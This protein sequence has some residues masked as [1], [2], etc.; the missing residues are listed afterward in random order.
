MK[1]WT[2]LSH[3]V[4]MCAMSSPMFV[5]KCARVPVYSGKWYPKESRKCFLLEIVHQNTKQSKWCM[6]RS[7]VH[8]WCLIPFLISTLLSLY[9]TRG[10]FHFFSHFLPPYIHQL[11]QV[12]TTV[13]EFAHVYPGQRLSWAFLSGSASV[14]R[15]VVC[16][17]AELTVL[18][19]FY[20]AER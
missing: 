7:T 3:R 2:L 5:N 9:Q 20:T 16:W 18:P 17:P 8:G 13:E 6:H 12:T 19:R 14:V 4:H 11:S 15:L 1:R 10:S